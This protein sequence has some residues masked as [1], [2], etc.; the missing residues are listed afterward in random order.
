[1]ASVT[2]R[3]VPEEDT[4]RARRPRSCDGVGLSRSTSRGELIELARRPDAVLL[5]R[6]RITSR[7]RATGGTVDASTILR[8]RD[9]DR[10]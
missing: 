5:H 8:H 2:I 3:E 4:R 6:R 1:M 9:A 7:K 10:R